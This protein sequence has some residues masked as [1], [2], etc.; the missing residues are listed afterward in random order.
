MSKGIIFREF[1]LV[2]L[3]TGRACCT[4]CTNCACTNCC[5]NACVRC[6]NANVSSLLWSNSLCKSTCAWGTVG[7][8]KL[9]IFTGGAI[10]V[11]VGNGCEDRRAVLTGAVVNKEGIPYVGVPAMVTEVGIILGCVTNPVPIPGI[12]WNPVFVFVAPA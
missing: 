5:C 12:A 11:V 1:T 2:R 9:G 6:L 10:G 4:G 8:T 7:F 3:L